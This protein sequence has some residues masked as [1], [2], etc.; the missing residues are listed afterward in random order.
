MNVYSACEWSVTVI[1]FERPEEFG[2]LEDAHWGVETGAIEGRPISPLILP[3]TAKSP[4][5]EVTRKIDIKTVI[6]LLL[7]EFLIRRRVRF[8]AQT[9]YLTNHFPMEAARRVP[10][11]VLASTPERGR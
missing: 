5:I 6:V 11:K 4:A 8:P 1:H 2:F 7:Q 3:E 9:D 10:F